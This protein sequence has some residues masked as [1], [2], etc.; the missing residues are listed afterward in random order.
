M[1]VASVNS[2]KQAGL[3]SLKLEEKRTNA[4]YRDDERD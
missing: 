3:L 1:R 4:L 2:A